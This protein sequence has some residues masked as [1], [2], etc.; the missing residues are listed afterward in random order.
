[1]VLFAAFV[2]AV[3]RQSLT[4]DDLDLAH[5]RV[6]AWH[7]EVVRPLRAVRQRLKTGPMPAPN[8]A[9]AGL[10]RALAE[11]EIQAE[12][13]ELE[14]LGELISE[15]NSPHSTSPTA[16]FATAAIET[17]IRTQIG[18]APNEKDREAIAAIAAEAHLVDANR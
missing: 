17:V 1:M 5:R 3:R 18:I 12:V 13:I 4:V 11:L 8:D 15:I 7:H 9:T 2:G 16:E 6:D 14:Q 10:R